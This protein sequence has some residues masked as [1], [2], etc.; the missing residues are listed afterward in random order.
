MGIE[1]LVLHKQIISITSGLSIFT[2]IPKINKNAHH[3]ATIQKQKQ[4]STLYMC[5]R[6]S[7]QFHK[8]LCQQ[9]GEYHV[10]TIWV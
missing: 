10:K 2:P 6:W 8:S 9:N 7:V 1:K 4:T 3:M 5:F